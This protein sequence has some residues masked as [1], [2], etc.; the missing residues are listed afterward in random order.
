MNRLQKWIKHMK[1]L[2]LISSLII[3]VSCTSVSSTFV[4]ETN[5]AT[6]EKIDPNTVEIFTQKPQR[7]ALCIGKISTRGNGSAGTNDLMKEAK[8]K[9]AKLGGD[10]LLTEDYGVDSET[11]HSPAYTSFE[12][13]TSNKDGTKSKES[14]GE[15]RGASTS[16]IHRP[17]RKFSVWV[18]APSQLG[19][20]M[21]RFK[22]TS[23]H[24]NSDAAKNGVKIGDVLLGVDGHDIHDESLTQHLMRIHPGDQVKLSLLR[25]SETVECRIT[26]LPN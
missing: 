5:I 21:D 11:V 25:D 24:L 26:A 19:V 9:A 3:C 23:F 18:F 7:A 8:E 10:F 22:I 14:S 20:R 12:S 15:S 1:S 4:R 16:T 2:C 6:I 17:W 13:K